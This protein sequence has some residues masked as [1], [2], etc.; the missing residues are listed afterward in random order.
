MFLQWSIEKSEV[1]LLLRPQ[2]LTPGDFW[3][4]LRNVNF[5]DLEAVAVWNSTM[6][7]GRYPLIPI[8]EMTYGG[9]RNG[10]GIKPGRVFL[11]PNRDDPN[12]FGSENLAD[13]G[14]LGMNKQV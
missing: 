13:R 2:K 9:H 12:E 1:H 14:I 11:V 7:F 10:Y 4:A 5:T 3:N 8:R 6:E